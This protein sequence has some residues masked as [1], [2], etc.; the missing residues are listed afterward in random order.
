MNVQLGTNTDVFYDKFR[1]VLAMNDGFY[2]FEQK[3]FLGERTTSDLVTR[4]L[5]DSSYEI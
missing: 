1:K 3:N 2:Q 4:F 5:I